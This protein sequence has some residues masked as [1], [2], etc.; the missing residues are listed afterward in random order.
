MKAFARAFADKL[1]ENHLNVVLD[2]VQTDP[3]PK[4]ALADS[5]EVFMP[6]EGKRKPGELAMVSVYRDGEG[7]H[8]K[9]VMKIDLAYASASEFI[10]P[11]IAYA[12]K[13]VKPNAMVVCDGAFDFDTVGAGSVAVFPRFDR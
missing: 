1:R 5:C 7:E 9:L 12:T 6:S 4:Y 3:H 11:A 2:S 13:I 8:T 10:S